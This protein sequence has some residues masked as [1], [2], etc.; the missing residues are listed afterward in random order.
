MIA[1]TPVDPSLRIAVT[2]RSVADRDISILVGAQ[3]DAEFVLVIRTTERS[4]L[5]MN[6]SG[7]VSG[8]VDDAR[9]MAERAVTEFLF[10]RLDETTPREL[11]P[12]LIEKISAEAAVVDWSEWD[13]TRILVDDVGFALRIRQMHPGFVAIADLGAFIVT[14]RGNELPPERRYTLRRSVL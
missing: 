14:M 1:L 10:Q 8:I 6:D 2:D 11:L 12:A 13:F 4:G 3:G 5:R 7:H 9:T